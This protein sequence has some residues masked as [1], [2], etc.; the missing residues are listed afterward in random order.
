MTETDAVA[1][2]VL[3]SGTSRR[4]GQENKLLL[5]LDG[6]PVVRRVTLAYLTAG[7]DPVLVVLGHEADRLRAVL[8]DLPIQIIDN[9]DSWLAFTDMVFIDPVGTGYSRPASTAGHSH[10]L[11]GL[12]TP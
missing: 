8:G 10:R 7:L 12:T 6:V 5:Q 11:F 4:F 3:A 1:G 2:I 9:P